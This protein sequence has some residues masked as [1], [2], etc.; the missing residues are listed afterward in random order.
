RSAHAITSGTYLAQRQHCGL[1]T[2]ARDAHS[3]CEIVAIQA[4][5]IQ[6]SDL[7]HR[8]VALPAHLP[9]NPLACGARHRAAYELRPEA[10]VAIPVDPLRRPAILDIREESDGLAQ[11]IVCFHQQRL[12]LH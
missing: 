3:R 10:A 11:A 8:L 9:C 5:S 1:A 6:R 4:L 7:D 12:L 2:R